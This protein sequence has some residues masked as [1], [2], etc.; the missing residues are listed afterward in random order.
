MK[1]MRLKP[2]WKHIACRAWSFRLNAIA[3]I[4]S[5]L[6]SV[7]PL[8]SEDFPRGV[9]AAISFIIVA[10]ALWSRLLAQKNLDE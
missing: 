8:F 1:N 7:L 9:F 5:G 4:L 10:A 2:N 6:E 3:L